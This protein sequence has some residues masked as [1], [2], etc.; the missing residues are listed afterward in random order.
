MM[1]TL[2]HALNVLSTKMCIRDRSVKDTGPAGIYAAGDAD[3]EAVSGFLC[4]RLE[5]FF[6]MR[7]RVKFVV[8]ESGLC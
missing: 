2:Y 1:V 7:V 3:G 4:G 6:N 5:L 8:A